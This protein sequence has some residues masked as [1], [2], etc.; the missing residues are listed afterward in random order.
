MRSTLSHFKLC[1]MFRNHD[2]DRRYNAIVWGQPQKEGIIE[3]PI[4]RSFINRKKMA[5]SE[6]GK[7]A[8]T[9]WKI[10][11]ICDEILPSKWSLSYTFLEL[12][13]FGQMS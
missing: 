11:G 1:E 5:I 10:F 4:A 7:M 13:Y 3:K 8:L 9:K 2:L 12:F 6:K